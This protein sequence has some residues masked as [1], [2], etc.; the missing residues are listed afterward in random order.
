LLQQSNWF[1]LID[2]PHEKCPTH[3]AQ[4]QPP[5]DRADQVP[6][7]PQECVTLLA[8]KRNSG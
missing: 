3:A 1:V 5:V 4:A 2:Q 7:S 8:C 6:R